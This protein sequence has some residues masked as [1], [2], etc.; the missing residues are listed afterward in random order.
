[1]ANPEVL[2]S[3]FKNENETWKRILGY[4][5][6]ENINLKNHLSEILANMTEDR[7]GFLERVENF[8]D[9]LLKEDEIINFLNFELNEQNKKLIRTIYNNGELTESVEKN[10][11]KL[12]RDLEITE[13]HFNKLKFRFNSYLVENPGV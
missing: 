12:R 13:Q 5:N 7:N 11:K 8:N 10:Q 6:E 1:M 3:Q 2:L 4:L 9:L